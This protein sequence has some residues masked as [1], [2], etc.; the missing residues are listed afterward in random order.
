MYFFKKLASR[1][2]FPVPLCLELLLIGLFLLCFTKRQRAGKA[3][4]SLGTLL[5][6]LLSYS[7]V[8][9][10]LLGPIEA[11]YPPFQLPA[12]AAAGVAA[13]GCAPSPCPL[14]NVRS[15]GPTALGR[16]EGNCVPSTDVLVRY[17]AARPAATGPSPC[18]LPEG[19]GTEEAVPAATP[20]YVAVLASALPD[21]RLPMTSQ[22]GTSGLPRTIEGLRLH[23]A[24]PGSRLILSVGNPSEADQFAHAIVDFLTPFGLD[25]TRVD[26]I[27]G[28]NDTEEE[29]EAI[30]GIVGNKPFVLVTSASHIPRSMALART[31]GMNPIAAPTDHRVKRKVWDSP[32][33]FFPD[34]SDLYK[35][36]RAFYEYLG[37]AWAWARGRM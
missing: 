31:R 17:A 28:V 7:P 29:M 22:L 20:G 10:R 11:R 12:I 23:H 33:D 14:P 27:Q 2:L 13:Q 3:L 9:D 4:V 24:L 5:L 25:R 18:P 36:Q 26:M 8:A 16:G 37:M 30:H 6:A 34:A 35:S 1:L 15:E 19:E 21:P 32:D